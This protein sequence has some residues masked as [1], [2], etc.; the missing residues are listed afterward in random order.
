MHMSLCNPGSCFLFSSVLLLAPW[1]S[2]MEHKSLLKC[3]TFIAE[4]VGD[5]YSSHLSTAVPVVSEPE[6]CGR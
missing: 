6:V 5:S 3:I 1:L 2:N 4:L